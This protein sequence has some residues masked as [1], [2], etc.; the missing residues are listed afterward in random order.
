MD[1]DEVMARCINV[2]SE[3]HGEDNLDDHHTELLSCMVI[4]ASMPIITD[5]VCDTP[6]KVILM[7]TEVTK[8][9]FNLGIA[10]GRT[11]GAT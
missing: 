7:L 10:R 11:L 3:W 1:H 9:A 4:F 6:D 2:M 5:G 8:A